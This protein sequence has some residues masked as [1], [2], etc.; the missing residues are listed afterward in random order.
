MFVYTYVIWWRIK[1]VCYTLQ[2]ESS[3][4]QLSLW[5]CFCLLGHE[6][7]LAARKK[8]GEGQ[9]DPTA[10]KKA[11]A[12]ELVKP[13]SL[14]SIPRQPAIALMLAR[15][16]LRVSNTVTRPRIGVRAGSTLAKYNWQ[17]PLNLDKLLTDEE[18]M[19]RYAS[20][21]SV[22]PSGG[23]F[24]NHFVLFR[25]AARDYCQEKLQPRV[26]EAYRHERT[27]KQQRDCGKKCTWKGMCLFSLFYF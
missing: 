3:G 17:D 24:V 9:V 4:A 1:R 8:C 27:H 10:Y 6:N 19:V 7:K 26:L 25:D 21:L 23:K 2:R 13:F 18:R 15:Q 5:W 14:C 22:W 20:L 16:F 11:K 12:Q